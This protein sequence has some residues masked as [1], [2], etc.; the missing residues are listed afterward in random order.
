MEVHPRRVPDRYAA[1]GIIDTAKECGSDMIV[2]TSHGRRGM[3][4]ALLGSQ[5]TECLT[6]LHGAGVSHPVI[7]HAARLP[8][9]QL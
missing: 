7:D 1:E 8:A 2:M 5:T 9:Y 3:S 6:H 4:R